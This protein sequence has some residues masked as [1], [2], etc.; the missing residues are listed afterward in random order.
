MIPFAMANG[1][2]RY[3]RTLRA[4]RIP[5]PDGL[6]TLAVAYAESQLFDRAIATQD[7]A[8]RIAAQGE[9]AGELAEMRRRNALFKDHQKYRPPLADPKPTP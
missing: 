4:N 7:E 1:R 3:W 2:F 5:R 8:I 9:F 6:S